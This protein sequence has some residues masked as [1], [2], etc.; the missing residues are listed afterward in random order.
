MSS[1]NHRDA[2]QAG[3]YADP[4]NPALPGTGFR[5][6]RTKAALVVIDPQNDFLSPSGVSWPFFGESITENNTVANLDALFK[7]S[8][9]AEITVAVS[10]HY[11]YP[12]DHAWHFGGPL[13]KVMH[14]IGM[15]DRKGPTTMDGF[16]GSGA[17]FL[18]Q[19]KP[20]ILDGKTIVASPHKVYGPETNDLVLQLRKQG[21]SQVIL[22]GMAANLCIESHL[23]ELI[24]QGF[25]VVVVRD[26]TAGPR[27][28]EGD[29]YLAAL[30]NYRFLAHALWTT[31][32]TVRQLA[33]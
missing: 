18:E 6:D 28:P 9:A 7:A 4:S 2:A 19:Y 27:V 5:L 16:D 12:C 32:Q 23:R 25:E 1:E 24:E 33:A 30:V 13:E 15:F 21:V 8:K 22:A 10:P 29:G 31:E 3:P 17:D 11:Y 26:A 20:Y 14:D